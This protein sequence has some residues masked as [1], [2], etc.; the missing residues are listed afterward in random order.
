MAE[1]ASVV[2]REGQPPPRVTVPAVCQT[3]DWGQEQSRCQGLLWGQGPAFPG[4]WD[5]FAP[6]VWHLGAIGGCCLEDLAWR[7]PALGDKVVLGSLQQA[8]ALQ[9]SLREESCNGVSC[10]FLLCFVC[11]RGCMVRSRDRHLSVCMG[12]SC[13]AAHLGDLSLHPQV[14]GEDQ[15]LQT[16]SCPQLHHSHQQILRERK[17]MQGREKPDMAVPSSSQLAGGASAGH[18][19][20]RADRLRLWTG[21]GGF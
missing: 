19:A 7:A 1:R 14:W 9:P 3:G 11:W 2:G 6:W 18:G 20:I 4:H 16:C 17:K 21:G 8:P 5:P 10:S 13:I 15:G 12:Q